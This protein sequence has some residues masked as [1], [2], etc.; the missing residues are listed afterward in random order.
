MILELILRL[1]FNLVG[2]IINVLP[3]T[4]IIETYAFDL[5][6]FTKLLSFGFIIFPYDLFLTFI[7]NVLFWL[8]VQMIWAAT[9]WCYKKIP[10]VN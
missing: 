6:E 8:V 9:E 7:G 2:L 3:E 1:L 5:S 10:G 4:S